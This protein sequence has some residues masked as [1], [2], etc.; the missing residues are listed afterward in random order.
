MINSEKL[1]DEEVIAL[2][3]E[4][5]HDRYF[6]VITLRYENYIIK[7]C[8]SYVKDED[9]AE[10]LCQEILIK[11]FMQLK[12]F[13]R[14]AKFKTWLYSII[15]NTC[16][17]Y[18][19]K[20]KNKSHKVISEKLQEEMADLVDEDV[21]NQEILEVALIQLLE[22]ITPEEKLILLLKYKEK[23]SIK[24]IEATLGISASAVKM[25]LSRAKEKINKL[26]S[27]YQNLA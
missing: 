21:V 24:E 17:D 16:V 11:L 23:N 22:E 4:G 18:L 1:S 27:K 14:E 6:S 8:K 15:H 20:E 9:V 19:R 5:G 3:K 26:Y 7:K 12:N 10:D 2:L 13:R 25:R